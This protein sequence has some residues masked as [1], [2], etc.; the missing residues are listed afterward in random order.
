VRQ[1][2]SVHI[3]LCLYKP[4]RCVVPLLPGTFFP[5]AS[6]PLTYIAP[7]TPAAGGVFWKLWKAFRARP[8]QASAAR[9]YCLRAS[10]ALP[11]S[12]VTLD[13]AS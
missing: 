6:A 11:C 12:A 9:N 1:R 13:G 10:L 7:R 8:Y 2:Y 4:K 3:D 5:V